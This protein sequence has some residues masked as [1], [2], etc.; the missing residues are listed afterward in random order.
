MIERNPERTRKFDV[1]IN[2]KGIGG[3][4]SRPFVAKNPV[5]AGFEFIHITQNKLWWSFS[6]FENVEL[7]P[8]AFEAGSAANI[9]PETVAL[10]LHAEYATDAQEELLKQIIAQTQEAVNAGYQVSSTATYE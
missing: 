3:H 6:Q 2:L 10:T 1:R 9:I 5:L 4:S 8:V 7:T